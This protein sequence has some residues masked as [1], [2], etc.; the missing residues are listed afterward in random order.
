MRQTH[1][2]IPTCPFKKFSKVPEPRSEVS[3]TVQ[4]K[5]AR[6][7]TVR[8]TS[9]GIASLARQSPPHVHHR[10]PATLVTPFM[11]ELQGKFCLT[12]A[13]THRHAC[14]CT[15][16]PV[17][18][19]LR[20]NRGLHPPRQRRKGG[21]PPPLSSLPFRRAPP[22]GKWVPHCRTRGPLAWNRRGTL[23]QGPPEAA[24]RGPPGPTQHDHP[25]SRGP[26]GH[27]M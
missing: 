22:L 9:Q 13:G 7:I 14:W 25:G 12:S 8:H 2:H 23:R 10:L 16:V 20:A 26:P 18:L 3:N 19:R 1:Q 11:S 15:C 6:C 5:V 21:D 4:T 24:A 27:T 17:L